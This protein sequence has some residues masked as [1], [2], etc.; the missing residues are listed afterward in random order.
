MM[1]FSNLWVRTNSILFR[2]SVG[3]EAYNN[4]V[5]QFESWEK[6]VE[7]RRA[8]VRQRAEAERREAELKAVAEREEQER[9][10]REEGGNR[11]STTP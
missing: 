8:Q 9:K 10:K 6:D 5:K 4:Y 3:T 7:K 1:L 11:Q 2:G